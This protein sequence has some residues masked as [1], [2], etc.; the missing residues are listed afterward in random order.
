MNCPFKKIARNLARVARRA[1]VDL[2]RTSLCEM[3]ERDS[4]RITIQDATSCSA[5]F[6]AITEPTEEMSEQADPRGSLLVNIKSL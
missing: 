5:A 4:D 2:A 6:V 1:R 3:G